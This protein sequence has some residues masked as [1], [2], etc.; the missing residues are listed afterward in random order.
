MAE[1]GLCIAMAKMTESDA[2]E[3]R[4]T[5]GINSLYK[6]ITFPPIPDFSTIM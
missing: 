1:T 5:G 6:K 2:K 3:H 4:Y